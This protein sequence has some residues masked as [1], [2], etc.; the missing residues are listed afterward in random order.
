MNCPDR[1]TTDLSTVSGIENGVITVWLHADEVY[2]FSWNAA[3]A[4]NMGFTVITNHRAL[5]GPYERTAREHDTR[6]RRYE[7]SPF[8]APLIPPRSPRP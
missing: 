4:P 3:L 7:D 5:C 2:A 6:T 1:R 8:I